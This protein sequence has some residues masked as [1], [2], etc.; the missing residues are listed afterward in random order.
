MLCS[1]K[2]AIFLFWLQLKNNGQDYLPLIFSIRLNCSLNSSMNPPAPF[3]IKYAQMINV[4][5]NYFCLD[6]VYRSYW[7][8]TICDTKISNIRQNS[9]TLYVNADSYESYDVGSTSLL[10][11]SSLR[12]SLQ[13][14]VCLYAYLLGW[15]AFLEAL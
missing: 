15:M 10:Y 3:F 11:L 7:Y 9:S 2:V 1:T 14:Y 13:D 12:M 8:S 6:L 5:R 4:F